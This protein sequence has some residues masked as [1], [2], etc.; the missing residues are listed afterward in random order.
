MTI[1]ECV[2][3]TLLC[4]FWLTMQGCL[5]IALVNYATEPIECDAIRS[6]RARGVTTTNPWFGTC[7]QKKKDVWTYELPP[8]VD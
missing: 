8:S 5:P 3:I 2:T 1:K 7:D 4:F 6:D